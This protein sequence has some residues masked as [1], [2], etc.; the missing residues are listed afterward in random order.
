MHSISGTQY[1]TRNL[2]DRFHTRGIT[3]AIIYFTGMQTLN[4][5]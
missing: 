5:T 1:G 4:L 2:V 3:I